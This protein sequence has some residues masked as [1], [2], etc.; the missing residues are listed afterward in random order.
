MTQVD[1]S[2]VG[3][4]NLLQAVELLDQA[5]ARD[6]T[7]VQ[8]YCQLASA[9]YVLYAQFE[10]TPARI[11]LADAAVEAA[12][13][14]APED[15]EVHLALAKHFFQGPMDFDRA[16]TEIALAQKALPNGLDSFRLAASID[17]RQGRW[18]ECI[19]NLQRAAELD[20][21]NRGALQNLATIFLQTRRYPEA[22]AAFERALAL[23]PN[24]ESIR[25]S[26]AALQLIWHAD[27]HP[28]HS[29]IDLVLRE[30][31]TAAPVHAD[32]LLYAALCERD[33][34]TTRR[35]IDALAGG[36]I[37][38]GSI[39]LN[40]DVLEGTLARM[41]GDATTAR[42]AFTAARIEQEKIVRA[43]PDY[44]PAVCALGLI[45]AGLG[46]REDA[47]SEG[48]R[49]LELVPLAKDA[50]TGE[51]MIE[52]FAVICAWVG[53]KDLAFEQLARAAQLPG[54][55]HYGGLRLHPSWDPLR[56]DPRFEKIV[57]SLAPKSDRK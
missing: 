16:R 19:R 50:L 56:D 26:K 23:A 46:R 9:H 21:R 39:V 41:S 13:H 12:R 31:P 11:A 53:E 48:R 3:K 15:G 22:D 36:P 38:V 25:V 30:N 10:H 45:D 44:G 20:P 47:L 43:Q 52:F 29:T 55:L 54:Q 57:A 1:T 33:V 18:E 2:D 27:P 42:A 17:R 35:A 37:R 7:F 51:L 24:N 49:A 4:N 40:H 5:V 34:A 28:L 14:L 8:G 6:P 32:S